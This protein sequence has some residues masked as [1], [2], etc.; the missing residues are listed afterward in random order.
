MIS[1]QNYAGIKQSYTKP[2]AG[3]CAVPDNVTPHTEN[4]QTFPSIS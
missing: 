1:S 2:R 3:K 4:T